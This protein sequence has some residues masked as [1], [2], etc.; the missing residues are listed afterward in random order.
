MQL[1]RGLLLAGSTIFF[2]F[3]IKLMPLAE[4]SSI[5]FIAPMLVTLMGGFF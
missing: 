4:T 2:V 1:V 3:A 5:T